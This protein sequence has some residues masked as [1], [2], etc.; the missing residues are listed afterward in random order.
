MY[1]PLKTISIYDFDPK[2]SKKAVPINGKVELAED[3][4]N[5]AIVLNNILKSGNKRKKLSNLLKD[6]L[7]FVEKLDT[8]KLIDKS[9]LLKL[10]ETYH[11]DKYLPA[12]Q[13]SDGT[14]NVIALVIALYFAEK[15]EWSGQEEL[16]TIIEE[17]E[18]NIHPKLISK[19]G[20]MMKEA[21]QARQIIAT[22]HNPE[23]VKHAD[24]DDILLVSR[25]EDGFST[26][27]R[28]REKPVLK[29]FLKDEIGIEE[30]YVQ[31]LLGT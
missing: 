28:P 25:S 2:L 30:L 16:L 24:I 17:P 7:P 23:M 14:L 1:P 19:V 15:L 18:R 26:I 22:T 29:E 27:S 13:I 21:S 12:P 4:S 31:G 10:R 5:L 9:L 8:S 6:L 11:T 3:G 20:A